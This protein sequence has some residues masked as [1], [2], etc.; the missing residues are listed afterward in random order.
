MLRSNAI[1]L[2]TKKL[3]CEFNSRLAILVPRHMSQELHSIARV[4][5]KGSLQ[6]LDVFMQ[7]SLDIEPYDDLFHVSPEIYVHLAP[8]VIALKF[9]YCEKLLSSSFIELFFKLPRISESGDSSI[10]MLGCFTWGEL[11]SIRG[12]IK[13]VFFENAL[14]SPYCVQESIREIESFMEMIN[15][16]IARRSDSKVH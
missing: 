11:E 1:K 13:R 9:L 12:F 4:D 3:W 10:N 6:Q 16:E 14:V 15:N 7:E 8:R 5:L 2:E